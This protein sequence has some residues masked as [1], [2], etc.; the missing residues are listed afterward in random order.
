[1]RTVTAAVGGIFVGTAITLGA[2]AAMTAELDRAHEQ[3]MA[4]TRKQDTVAWEKLVTDD[5]LVV[6]SDGRVLNKV[7]RIEDIK[8][9]GGL[10][11]SA[12]GLDVLR[13]RADYRVRM[14]GDTSIVTWVNPPDKNNPASLSPNGT[15]LVRVFVKQGTQWRMAHS[16]QTSLR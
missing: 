16:Q 4:A 15:R 9:G 13:K 2:Q 1:M 7:Q 8:K 5:I 11:L 3:M 14:Y 6:P 12:D 10:G